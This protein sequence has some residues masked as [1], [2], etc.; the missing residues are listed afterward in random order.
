MYRHK[1]ETKMTPMWNLSFTLLA[2]VPSTVSSGWGGGVID[3]AMSGKRG[4][5]TGNEVSDGTLKAGSYAA[6]I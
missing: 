3:F 5:M 1:F 4:E 2:R 6:F